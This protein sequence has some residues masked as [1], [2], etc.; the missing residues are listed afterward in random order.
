VKVLFLKRYLNADE[1]KYYGI[2]QKG[3]FYFMRERD[4]DFDYDFR[5]GRR[6]KIISNHSIGKLINILLELARRSQNDDV[7]KR[8]DVLRRLQ[9]REYIS[10]P[11]VS[12]YIADED[13]YVTPY[14]CKRHCSTV[15][16]FKISGRETD[17]YTAYNGNFE[18]IWKSE[19]TTSVI[20][21]MFL[22]YLI[23]E[24][25]R[26]LELFEHKYKEISD[27][28]AEK[29]RRNPFYNEDPERYR[30]EEKTITEVINSIN[31]L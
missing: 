25:K 9:I 17:L 15:P 24:P 26:I 3:D 29:V 18:A 11:S 8:R 21:E 19:Q 14:L 28:E 4:E 16:A 27:Y 13:I 10:L 22:Q 7:D 23:N 20:N 1:C 12:L 2:G 30:L 31:S 6:L 5:R